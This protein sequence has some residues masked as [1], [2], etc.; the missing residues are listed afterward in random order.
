MQRDR[1]PKNYCVI[2]SWHI[3]AAESGGAGPILSVSTRWPNSAA[4]CNSDPGEVPPPA[5]IEVDLCA[6]HCHCRSVKNVNLKTRQRSLLCCSIHLAK[7][8]FLVFA[9]GCAAPMQKMGGAQPP[10][11]SLRVVASVISTLRQS[12][13][14]NNVLAVDSRHR[15]DF[16]EVV[17]K[18]EN[19]SIWS[20]S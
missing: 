10:L 4:V 19:N 14:L 9:V 2:V 15:C 11:H 3:A 1:W 16:V 13:S 12:T 17:R 20:A 7:K 6:P 5:N 18:L 8:V